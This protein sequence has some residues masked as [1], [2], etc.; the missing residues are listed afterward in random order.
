MYIVSGNECD[1]LLFTYKNYAMRVRIQ[2]VNRLKLILAWAASTSMYYDSISLFIQ[3]KTME[4]GER[5]EKVGF[6]TGKCECTGIWGE[7]MTLGPHL[8]N[9]HHCQR[10]ISSAKQ[11]ALGIF[12]WC[13]LS[14]NLR[15]KA[16]LKFQAHDFKVVS[17]LYWISGGSLKYILKS[18]CSDVLK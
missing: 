7:W 10:K 3:N 12:R 4:W 11:E 8:K 17:F 6:V 16:N 13:L 2:N 1:W 14:R 15:K 9:T 18:W 5:D